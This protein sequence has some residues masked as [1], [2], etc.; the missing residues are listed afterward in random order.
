MGLETGFGV[1][2]ADPNL[3]LMV[4][5]TV[6][7]LVAHQ[8][9]R[10]EEWGFTGSVRFDPGLSGPRARRSGTPA[11]SRSASRRCSRGRRPTAGRG[12]RGD[13]GAGGVVE[14]GQPGVGGRPDGSHRGL[15]AFHKCNL[16]YPCNRSCPTPWLS[17][18]GSPEAAPSSAGTHAPAAALAGLSEVGGWRCGPGS[19][20]LSWSTASLPTRK[21][22]APAGTGS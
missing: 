4:D 10:Y 13:A 14:R 1:V 20:P 9:S 21:P 7:L 19:A 6:N 18:G 3:G 2:F 11:R 16:G 5:A 17:T 8:D 22:L 15:S 12:R